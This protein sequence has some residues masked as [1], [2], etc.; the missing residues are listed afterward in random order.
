M[1]C[2]KSGNYDPIRSFYGTN[3]VDTRRHAECRAHIGSDSCDGYGNERPISTGRGNQIVGDGKR[4][5]QDA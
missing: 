1:L 5:E 4:I 2:V 3:V